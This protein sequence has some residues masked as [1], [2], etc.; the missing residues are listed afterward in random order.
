MRAGAGATLRSQCPRR[1]TAP[2]QH[3]GRPSSPG[4]LAGGLARGAWGRV[5]P[6]RPHNLG[7]TQG[8][9][10]Q[11]LLESGGAPPHPVFSAPNA[12]GREASA[13]APLQPRSPDKGA[14]GEMGGAAKVKITDPFIKGKKAKIQN[15]TKKS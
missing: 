7:R 15:N 14:K 1:A 2:L 4:L 11:L 3:G 9:G 12:G 13:C 8:A 6:R 5:P 10:S